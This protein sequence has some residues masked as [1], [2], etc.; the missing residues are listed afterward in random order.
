VF[1]THSRD[2]GVTWARPREITEAVKKPHWRWY[3]TGPVNGIQL[4]RGAH[5]GR[6]VVPANHSDHSDPA[7]HPYRSHVIYSD[8]HGQTWQLGGVEEE[9]TNESTVVELADGSLLHN[10]RSYA[11]K[12][13]RA[14]ATSNNGGLN[15]STVT[16]DETL[17]EP[18]CQ[19]SI[20]RYS[21]P[22]GGEKSCV[23]FSNPASVKRQNMTVRLSHDEGK[24][25]PA[26]RT[27]HAGPSAYSCLVVLP[28]RTVGC[29][30]ESGVT[31]A[32]ERIVFARFPLAW[33]TAS[34]GK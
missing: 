22:E 16:L 19:A 7:R 30:Y 6:L 26:S 4:T 23:L 5:K 28:D 33:L 15:W 17:V 29:L 1:V 32:S 9:M 14:I 13:R 3:A 12:N 24:S 31:N 20:L 27:L 34:E 21:W 25:W 10:M 2:D 8:D 18:V 11:G